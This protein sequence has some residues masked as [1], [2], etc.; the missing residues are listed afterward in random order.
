MQYTQQNFKKGDVLHAEQL[1]S[2]DKAIDYLV[3]QDASTN[4]KKYGLYIGK[5]FTKGTRDSAGIDTSKV[6]RVAMSDVITIPYRE[7]SMTFHLPPH[8]LVGIRHGANSKDLSK[9]DY[10][11][12]N[13]PVSDNVYNT[14]AYKGNVFTFPQTTTYYSLTFAKD[15]DS[16]GN[17]IG[18][19]GEESG[20]SPEEISALVESGEI[21]IELTNQHD[22]TDIVA[23]NVGNGQY[24][25]QQLYANFKEG[26]DLINSNKPF[27]DAGKQMVLVHTSDVHGDVYRARNFY[28]YADYI[29]AD[30][31]L[32][33]GDVVAWSPKH[34][35]EYIKDLANSSKIPTCYCTGNH[36][37]YYYDTEEK[38]YNNTV[39]GFETQ[40]NYQ[41]ALDADGKK[42]AYYYA[43]NTKF[44]IRVIALNQYDGGQTATSVMSVIN[45]NQIEWFIQTLK[46]TPAG[47][48][49][50]LLTHSP[51]C[52]SQDKISSGE[53]TKFRQKYA[54]YWK[55]GYAE[56][57][58]YIP[59]IKILDAFIGRTSISYT[60]KN[61]AVS[62]SSADG[63]VTVSFE[64]DFS[65]VDSTVE[66]IGHFNGHTHQDFVGYYTE[67][68]NKVL[69]I[70]CTCGIGTYG[71]SEYRFLADNSDLPRGNI[72]ITQD[73]FNMYVI[74]RTRK[75]LK[76]ARVGS[77][78][79]YDGTKRD[80]TEFSYV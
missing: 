20:I 13:T 80:F 5:A 4:E 50:I 27:E 60:Y 54:T 77:N 15:V 41:V 68:T 42:C 58:N 6:N 33:T 73:S 70:N 72:G 7:A 52:S 57:G 22:T 11:Y 46:S 24:I 3:K 10:W 76:I 26:G 78:T 66:F 36:D 8:Y 17:S 37:V 2:M 39:R 62:S 9:N 35:M 56:S 34:G 16:N 14:T 69:C 12:G 53:N 30:M 1:N 51:E 21:F 38:I 19:A 25:A 40:G 31:C 61:Y 47:Y 55:N 48:G 59:L 67:A 64:A 45:K 32:L 49:I 63:T 43:D 44:K 65:D 71:N 18:I 23:R 74:D 79:T 75:I 29:G 28:Q